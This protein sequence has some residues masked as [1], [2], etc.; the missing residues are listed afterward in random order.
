MGRKPGGG[1]PTAGAPGGPGNGPRARKGP[2]GSGGAPAPA[3]PAPRPRPPAQ[4][5]KARRRGRG[6]PPAGAPP[7]GP[8]TGPPAGPSGAIGLVASKPEAAGP[9][10]AQQRVEVEVAAELAFEVAA[11]IAWPVF[12][13]PVP[14][15]LDVV[16]V[17]VADVDRLVGPVVRGLANRPAG[18]PEAAVGIGEAPA[19]RVGQRDVVQAGDPIR[20]RRPVLGLPGVEAEMMVIAPGRKKQQIAGGAPAGDISRLRNHIESEDVDVERPD[21]VDVGC[22]QMGMA[23]PNARIDRVGGAAERCDIAL[24]AHCRPP[25][26]GL[27][28]CAPIGRS[29]TVGPR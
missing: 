27:L 25:Y 19:G 17:R 11:I 18:I 26:R 9:Q 7:P 2:E 6:R 8:Q 10:I 28:L 24:R 22:A 5:P 12:D 21:P 20:L 3:P 16:A 1:D 15:Q 4:C 29:A 14:H 23:D 13:G